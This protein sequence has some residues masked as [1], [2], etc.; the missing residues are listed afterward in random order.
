MKKQTN[1]DQQEPKDRKKEI[2]EWL[3]I[4]IAA[5]V[6]AFCLNTFVVAN[7]RGLHGEYHHDRGPDPWFQA[8]L[9][10]WEYT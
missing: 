10:F 3:Q 1:T 2:L 8:F 4:I 9:L 6:I 7:S 5:A